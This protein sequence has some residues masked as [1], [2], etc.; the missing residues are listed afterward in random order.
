MAIRGFLFD[1]DGLLVDTE[2]LHLRAFASVAERHGLRCVAQDLRSWVGKGQHMLAAWIA[3]EVGGGDPEALV[4]E[5]RREFFTLLETERPGPQ[6]GASELLAIS[7]EIEFPVGL[8]SNSDRVFVE[9]IMRVVLPHMGR[10]AALEETFQAVIT[11]DDVEKPKPAPD[12]YLAA[13]RALGLEARECMAFE[14][15]PSGVLS[16]KAAGCLV[17]AVPCPW[18]LDQ[19]ECT[20]P[21]DIVYGSLYEAA[22]RR[23]WED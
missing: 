16:A 12:P 3:Q 22:L 23:A 15:S 14:D 8:V 6:P 1:M 21:A 20:H 7:E 10:P 11:R 18:L 9:A 5:Q 4:E 17:V 13:A 2:D 19:T